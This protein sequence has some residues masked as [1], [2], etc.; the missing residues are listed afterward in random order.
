MKMCVDNILIIDPDR[1]VWETYIALFK[2]DAYNLEFCSSFTECVE[3]VSDIQFEC[4]IMDVFLPDMEGWTAVPI[5]KQLCPNLKIIM[6]SAHN[7]ILLESKV[8]NQNVFY[9]HIKS[10]DIEELKL[11]VYNVFQNIGKMKEVRKVGE[12]PKILIIDD[13]ADFTAAVRLSLLNKHYRVDVAY[14]KMEGMDK[15]QKTGPDLILL[16]IMMEHIDD[17]FTLCYELK[18]NNSLKNIPVFALSSINQ[19]TQLKFSPKTDGEYFAADDFMEKPVNHEELIKR[20]ER[21]LQKKY[22]S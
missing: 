11:A 5:I 19:A 14:T 10:L 22:V 15:I 20:I 21:L 18:H 8:R 1:D 9:Y 6:T 12:P 7:S 16:D 13:D 3:M 4:L 17:G 2:N